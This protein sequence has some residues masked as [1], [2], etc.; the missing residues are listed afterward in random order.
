MISLTPT[1][2]L[3]IIIILLVVLIYA[4]FYSKYNKGY[5][6]TQT[7]LDKINLNLLY[8][9]NPIIIYDSIKTPKQL[10]KTLFK[11]SYLT[12]KEYTINTP[13]IYQSKSKFSFIYHTGQKTQHENVMINL[14]NPI[15]KKDF[16]NW[17]KNNNGVLFT[18]T[19][20]QDTTVEFV[21][22]KLK[23]HQVLLVPSHWMLQVVDDED[24]IK[25]DIDDLFTYIYFIFTT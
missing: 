15:F 12:K 13:N 9:R 14:I 20:L 10:L 24:V 22:V 17:K 19:P 5:N 21:S 2:L 1:R 11:Y 6:I 18:T 8:E 4:Q 3:I 25:I 16:K 7:Y 23:A